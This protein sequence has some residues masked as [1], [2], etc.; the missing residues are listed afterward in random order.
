MHMTPVPVKDSLGDIVML[1]TFLFTSIQI[2][3]TKTCKEKLLADTIF[4]SSS[5]N[6]TNIRHPVE[7]GPFGKATTRRTVSRSSRASRTVTPSGPPVD[8]DRLDMQRQQ[9]NVFGEWKNTL[10]RSSPN[11][12]ANA[13]QA[14]RQPSFELSPTRSTSRE[15]IPRAGSPDAPVATTQPPDDVTP[16]FAEPT[17]VL[18]YGFLPSQQPS[19][20][21][22]FETASRGLIYEDY[23]RAV[24]NPR[25]AQSSLLAQTNARRAAATH[26]AE[27]GGAGLTQDVL[28]RIN[29]YKGGEHWIKVT[30]DSPTAAE[31]AIEASPHLIG[32]CSVR[33]ERWVG[34]GPREDKAIPAEG[35]GSAG[36]LGRQQVSGRRT[37]RGQSRDYAS[38]PS[39]AGALGG[40]TGGLG[41][42]TSST[43]T[44]GA[45]FNTANT[46]TDTSR[47]LDAST[48]SATLTATGMEV[49]GAGD[50]QVEQRAQ[51]PAQPR[52][53]PQRKPKIKGARTAVL[54]PKEK[55]LLPV[56]PWRT[57][58][59]ASIPFI[60]SLLV[61]SSVPQSRNIEEKALPRR[62]D[63]SVD[64]SRAS[65][66]WWLYRL[67]DC[68]TG[69]DLCGIQGDGLEKQS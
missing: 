56:V 40:I 69:A 22:F 53:I 31:R 23:D 42:S 41:D 4:G 59:L 14:T 34:Q 67:L 21:A 15:Q 33:A 50:A 11:K 66:G 61:P 64:W 18:I 8:P 19:V 7:R 49:S 51:T 37:G 54:Q 65:W 48:S 47:T 30:F 27:G 45:S 68:L 52:E 25:Y 12:S 55:A 44:A 6:K 9:D 60:G 43:E 16:I 10:E 13:I 35:R 24:A 1:S 63:G 5:M 62:K 20:L 58:M 3:S 29:E 26:A 32:G 28:R 46:N 39:R 2:S 36:T 57:Q 17:E 38:L